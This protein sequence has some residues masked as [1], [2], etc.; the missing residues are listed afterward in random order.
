MWF[1]TNLNS[2]QLWSQ[3]LKRPTLTNLWSCLCAYRDGYTSKL[4][5]DVIGDRNLHQRT[6]VIEDL[7]KDIKLHLITTLPSMHEVLPEDARTLLE[8]VTENEQYWE[9]L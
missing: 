9:T 1:L 8:I 4:K 7:S 6:Q 2:I 3:C 5:R